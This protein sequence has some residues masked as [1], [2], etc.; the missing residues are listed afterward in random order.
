MRARNTR[1]IPSMAIRATTLN[2]PMRHMTHTS[3]E[4]LIMFW[5]IPFHTT[6]TELGAAGD[7]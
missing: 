4:R 6:D 3:V 2:L 5:A 7:S 1:T